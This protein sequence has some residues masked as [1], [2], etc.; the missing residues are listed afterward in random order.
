RKSATSWSSSFA[1][2]SPATSFQVTEAGEP[3]VISCGLT[4]GISRTIRTRTKTTTHMSRKNMTG[5]HVEVNSCIHADTLARSIPV[6]IGTR[7]LRLQRSRLQLETRG[8]R[9][10]GD[11]QLLGRRLGGREPVLELVARPGQ[12]PRQGMLRMALHPAEELRR[13]GEPRDAG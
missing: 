4:R 10:L 13:G 6:V 9:G 5:T 12:R 1:S 3:L 7:P 8:E 11:L 2:S